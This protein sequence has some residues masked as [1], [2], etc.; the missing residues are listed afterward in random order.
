MNEFTHRST[1][2]VRAEWFQGKTDI[3]PKIFDFVELP[4][5][6]ILSSKYK[7]NSFSQSKSDTNRKFVLEQYNM[8]QQAL[9]V[10]QSNVT[11]SKLEAKKQNKLNSSLLTRILMENLIFSHP[12][13]SIVSCSVAPNPKSL[14]QSLTAMQFLAQIRESIMQKVGKCKLN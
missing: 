7:G 13:S 1:L 2:V 11:F 6:N 12:C 10:S 9:V 8:L 5:T 14:P 3:I 4:I